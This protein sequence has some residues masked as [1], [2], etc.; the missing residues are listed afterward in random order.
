MKSVLYVFDDIN[1][2]SGAQKIMLYQIKTLMN[3]YSISV[4]SLTKP[5]HDI[6]LYLN[7]VE[8]LDSKVWEKNNFINLS[9]RD[10]LKDRRIKKRV[11]LQRIAYSV[12]NYL[13]LNNLL[14]K[15]LIGTNIL[16]KF[17]EFKTIIVTSE[18]SRL[19]SFISS[20]QGPKKIQWIHTDYLAW[21][22]FSNWTRSIT[23]ND[24]KIYHSYD[25]IIA[26][27]MTSKKG[28]LNKIP[29]LDNKVEVVHNLI[30]IEEIVKKSMEPCNLKMESGFV[31][32]ITIGRLDIEKGYDRIIDLCKKC[33]SSE[34][35]FKWYIVGD[36]PLREYLEQKI[37]EDELADTL[38]LLG[39]VDNPYPIL[40]QADYFVLFSEYEGT[41]VTIYESLILNI[42]VIA[43]DVGGIREQ[44]DNGKYGIL[45]ENNFENIY[46]EL[47]Q[48]LE[49]G[50]KDNLINNF[51][52][53]AQVHNKNII[54]QLE[55]L[56]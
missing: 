19:R 6:V 48:I 13:S 40:K 43:T 38:I 31:N 39:K 7:G 1:Y 47:T 36:G 42:P 41:P 2:T 25:K 3:Q 12:A 30:Q 45:V 5:H 28:L 34:L 11:K 23:R 51:T 16:K 26:L 33:K 4:F 54:K 32:I 44:L 49:Y 10:V 8:F 27:T 9:L 14:T 18:G 52:E 15:M 29:V 20:L 22:N 35:V 55:E 17:S 53:L 50:I 21:S 56:I 24:N 46:F 37:K